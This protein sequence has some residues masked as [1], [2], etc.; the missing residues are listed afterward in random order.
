MLVDDYMH[1]TG[2][3]KKKERNGVRYPSWFGKRYTKPLA[4]RKEA[5][6]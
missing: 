6:G 5:T 1:T 3:P 2:N 4:I